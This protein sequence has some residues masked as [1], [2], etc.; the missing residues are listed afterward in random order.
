MLPTLVLA[1]VTGV[2]LSDA[3]VDRIVST[4]TVTVQRQVYLEFKVFT[5]DPLGSRDDGTIKS[6]AQPDL[7]ALHKQTATFM[8][9]HPEDVR[10]GNQA[11]GIE[12]KAIPCLRLDG[13]IGLECET[14]ITT[15][16]VHSGIR[17]SSGSFIAGVSEEVV[18]VAVVLSPGK[19][20]KVRLSA[21]SITDQ[22]WMELT[23]TVV[24][25][26]RTKFAEEASKLTWSVTGT[27]TP[28]VLPAAYTTLPV[29]MMMPTVT[30]TPLPPAVAK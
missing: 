14:T 19:S 7:T 1:C 30:P 23:A 22:T 25:D 8:V 15:P 16:K 24:E 26:M 29:P 3:V 2:P 11:Q 27:A 17:L 20:H 12:I 6:I 5:G 28:T 18:K 21:K 10:S 9:G 4:R 13:K